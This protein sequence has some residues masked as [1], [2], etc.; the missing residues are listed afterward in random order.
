MLALARFACPGQVSVMSRRALSEKRPFLLLAIA[1]AVAYWVLRATS[2]PEFYLVPVKGLATAMLATY[3]F[4][5]FP[6]KDG[7]LLGMALICAALG[8]MAMEIDTT[9]GGALFFLFHVL[10]L[11]LFVKFRRER[12]AGSQKALVLILLVL[13]PVIAFLLPAERI[14]AMQTAFYGLALGAMTAAAWASRFPRYRVGAGAVLFW[15]SDMLIFARMGPLEN[16]LLAREAVYPIYFIGM[17]M[18][19][20]GVVQSLRRWKSESRLRA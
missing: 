14:W 10:M 15:F 11:G 12:M 7:R 13:T 8:D 9:V 2:F 19:C 4:V 1:F 18:V 16:S 20:T 6:G 5:R 17:I 3:A